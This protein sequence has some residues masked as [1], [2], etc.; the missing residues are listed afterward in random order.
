MTAK[1]EDIESVLGGIVGYDAGRAVAI[2]V[3]DLKADPDRAARRMLSAELVNQ[4]LSKLADVTGVAV[5]DL[6]SVRVLRATNH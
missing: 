6:V 3:Y 5:L 2:G 4:G 1:H